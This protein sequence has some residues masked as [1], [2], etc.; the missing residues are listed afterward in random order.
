MIESVNI[1]MFAIFCPILY[2]KLNYFAENCFEH[3]IN[4]IT[5]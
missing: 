3:E 1:I 5:F 4:T 2:E